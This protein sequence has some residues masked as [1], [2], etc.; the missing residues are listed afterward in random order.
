VLS[1]ARERELLDRACRAQDDE[2]CSQ[3][4][5]A[6]TNGRTKATRKQQ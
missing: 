5:H 1:L 3:L 4:S 2:A 6:V